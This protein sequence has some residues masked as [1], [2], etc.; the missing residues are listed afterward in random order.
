ML[1]MYEF[2]ECILSDFVIQYMNYDYA[3]EL[4]LWLL[5]EFNS[6]CGCMGIHVYIEQVSL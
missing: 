2:N 4:L 3:S 6:I 1:Y 5:N